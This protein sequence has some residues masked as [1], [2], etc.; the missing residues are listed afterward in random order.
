MET[1]PLDSAA[2]GIQRGLSTIE[3]AS[4][5]IASAS[6]Q[7]G[8]DDR[9]TEAVAELAEGK[10]Q[11]QASAKSLSAENDVIGALLSTKA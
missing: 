11:A 3:N 9:T 4:A 2:T 8:K 7:S 5:K 1:P 10:Q 6:Q